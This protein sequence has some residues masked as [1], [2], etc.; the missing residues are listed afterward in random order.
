MARG[1]QHQQGQQGKDAE[2]FEGKTG[3]TAKTGIAGEQRREFWRG[4]E[5][6]IPVEHEH[7]MGERDRRRN[8]AQVAPV[9]EQQ[10][11]TRI[12]PGERTDRQHDGQQQ[13]GQ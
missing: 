3:N 6:K 1:R 2:Q 9:V 7:R 4:A 12:E 5:S 8:D 10:Q 11:K 13:K